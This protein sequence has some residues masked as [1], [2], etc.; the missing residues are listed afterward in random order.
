MAYLVDTNTCSYAMRRELGVV[1]RFAA[2]DPAGVFVSVVTLAEAWTGARK[3]K[4]RKR[5][6]Q[7]WEYFLAP[8]RDRVLPFDEAAADRYADIRARLEI[9]GRMIGDRDCM[10]AGIA[11]SKGLAVVTRNTR[12]FRRVPGLRVVDWTAE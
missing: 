5:I 2:H 1:Q 12:E 11:L 3:S 10:I 8:F 7:Q 9:E 6:E 4:R